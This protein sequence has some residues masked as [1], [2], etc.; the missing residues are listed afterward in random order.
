[1][2]T[3]HLEMKGSLMSCLALCHHNGNVRYG[4]VPELL[5]TKV[6]LKSTNIGLA[7]S[8]YPAFNW[9]DLDAFWYTQKGIDK[10][11]LNLHDDY[12][13]LRF[14]PELRIYVRVQ[15]LG[16]SPVLIRISSLARIFFYDVNDQKPYTL[17]FHLTPCDRSKW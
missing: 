10:G 16:I 14:S 13:L 9:M 4:D 3:K 6:V 5:E 1:M 8:S 17:T 12:F 11:P 15:S 2:L 7:I